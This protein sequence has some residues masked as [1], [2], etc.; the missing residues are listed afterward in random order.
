MGDHAGT[1]V[2]ALVYFDNRRGAK[3]VADLP[4]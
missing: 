1:H 3:F 4:R 2:D